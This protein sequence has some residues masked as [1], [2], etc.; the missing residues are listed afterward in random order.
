L[1]LYVCTNLAN[2]GTTIVEYPHRNGMLFTW[3]MD[4]LTSYIQGA[5]PEM[6]QSEGS[7][8]PSLTKKL[9]TLK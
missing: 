7:K 2:W 9:E 3:L 4:F 5:G 6:S 8:Q 1:D